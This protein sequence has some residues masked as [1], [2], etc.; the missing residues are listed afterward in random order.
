MPNIRA[1]ELHICGRVDVA[2]IQKKK[3]DLTRRLTSDENLTLFADVS[4]ILLVVHGRK[5]LVND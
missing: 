2:G 4:D 1:A 5:K 3:G